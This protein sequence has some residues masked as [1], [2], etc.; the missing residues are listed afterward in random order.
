MKGHRISE[1]IAAKVAILLPGSRRQEL[2]FVRS[3]WLNIEDS[4]VSDNGREGDYWSRTIMKQ[5]YAYNLMAHVSGVHP[6]GGG[7]P[8]Y[9]YYG[10][11]LRC[12]YPG[13]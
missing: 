5:F 1:K 11:P 10:F 9:Y 7:V 8:G 2:A 4:K 12:L 3:G 13:K 6:D